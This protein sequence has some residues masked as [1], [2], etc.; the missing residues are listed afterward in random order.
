MYNNFGTIRGWEGRLVNMRTGA[1]VV[2]PN[3]DL[4]AGETYSWLESAEKANTIAAMIQ[5]RSLAKTMT[6]KVMASEVGAHST[7]KIATTVTQTVKKIDTEVM[8]HPKHNTTHVAE[9]KESSTP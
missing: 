3:T 1:L 5:K 6:P 8:T 7:S 2:N 4:I 9:A